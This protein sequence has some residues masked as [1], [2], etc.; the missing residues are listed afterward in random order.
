MQRRGRGELWRRQQQGG[1]LLGT[2]LAMLSWLGSRALPSPA[3]LSG[4]KAATLHAHNITPAG[5][6]AIP[7]ERQ[8]ENIV[9]LA[10]WAAELASGEANENG[11]YGSADLTFA[12][13]RLAHH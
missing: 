5:D 3:Y 11:T 4:R 7:S 10:G 9:A 12:L 6:G 1:R 13:S 2:K 8:R